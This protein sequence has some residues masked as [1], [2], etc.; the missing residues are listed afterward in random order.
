MQ[1]GKGKEVKRK[2]SGEGSDGGRLSVFGG[3]DKAGVRILWD[4]ATPEAISA[5]V[6]AVSSIGG[7][8]LFGGSRDQG[9]LLVTLHLDDERKNIWIAGGAEVDTELYK[10]FQKLEALM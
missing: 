8:I 9:A 4:E 3:S 6:C 7:A 10:I 5:L 2:R 1:Y